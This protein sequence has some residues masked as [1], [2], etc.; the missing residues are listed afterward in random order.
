MRSVTH[1]LPLAV[2]LVA[3]TVAGAAVPPPRS[4]GGEV[5]DADAFLLRWCNKAPIAT[6]VTVRPGTAG[7]HPHDCF[8]TLRGGGSL[9]IG[10]GAALTVTDELQIND[11]GGSPTGGVVALAPAPR[12]PPASSPSTSGR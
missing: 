6:P 5:V 2:L 9:T 8:L 7:V 12:S 10:A 3:A 4:G 11:V 1:A